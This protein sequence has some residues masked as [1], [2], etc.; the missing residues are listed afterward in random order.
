VLV[1]AVPDASVPV[2]QLAINAEKPLEYHLDLGAKLASLRERGVLILGSGN[3][4]HNLAGMVPALG[5]KGFDWAQRFDDEARVQL[6]NDPAGAVRLRDHA[7]YAAAVPTPDHFLPMLY[8]A[9]LAAVDGGAV[10]VLTD[11]YAYG[12]LSMTSYT[13]GLEDR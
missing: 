4:V 5:D 10:D 8:F 2:V 1:H 7:D 3:I 11:G 13:L 9:G 6:V 12:S